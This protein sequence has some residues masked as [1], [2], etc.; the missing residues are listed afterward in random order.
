ML[1]ES[2]S[3]ELLF[4]LKCSFIGL[5]VHNICII[6][7]A[8]AYGM[9][10]LG[11]QLQLLTFQKGNRTAKYIILYN[12]KAHLTPQTAIKSDWRPGTSSTP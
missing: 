11:L 2:I 4:N 10:L 3:V 1:K 12:I 7:K 6:C 8:S 9:G 5:M